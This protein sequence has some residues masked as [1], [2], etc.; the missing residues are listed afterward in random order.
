V[1]IIFSIFLTRYC[2]PAWK[3]TEE[4]SKGRANRAVAASFKN[5]TVK[6]QPT[7]KVARG[8]PRWNCGLAVETFA[9]GV[10]GRDTAHGTMIPMQSLARATLV[11]PSPSEERANSNT[12]VIQR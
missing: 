3:S 6:D 9:S 7:F 1:N 12:I 8:R 4:N 2:L 11:S 5:G 10:D